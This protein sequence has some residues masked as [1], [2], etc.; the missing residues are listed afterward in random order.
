MSVK[1]LVLIFRIRM[2]NVSRSL[3]LFLFCVFSLTAGSQQKD[4]DRLKKE[5]EE[6][7]KKIGFT[8]KLL[9]STKTNK[10]NLTENI[11]LIE[12]KIEYR[13]EL[14]NNLD[15]QLS[16]L[17]ME[18]ESMKEEIEALRLEIER[19]KAAYKAM[20][21]HAYKM[22]SSSSSLIFI[23]SSESFNQASKRMA[24]LKQLSK[25]R[26]DQIIKI[27]ATKKKL[28]TELADLELKKQE[29]DDLM[30]EQKSEH[31]KYISD[32]ESQKKQIE[33][34]KGKE[35]QLQ[36]ELAAQKKKVK[37]IQNA[38]NAALN[39]EILDKKKKKDEKPLTDKEIKEVELSNKGFEA[40]K[41]KLPWPVSKGEIT[42]GYGKQAHPVHINVYTQNNGVD[43]TTSKG[44]TVRAVYAGEVT[45]VILIPG[46]GKAVIIAHGDYR[47]IY[48]NLQEAYVTKGAKVETKQDIGYLLANESGTSEV[49]FEICKITTE[50]DIIHVN[51]TYW[52]TQ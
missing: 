11:G 12:R 4:S 13:D 21:V 31:T 47:S 45:S 43:I 5:Q 10:Q 27:Q 26:S 15:K 32:R 2:L 29:K 9:E 41:G 46:A 16:Q 36:Q 39:K 7:K 38:L 24:Y 3:L 14:L 52:I 44:A 23:L 17:S 30:V 33:N 35:T 6:L 34:L 49:H 50:G 1:K 20:L 28:D 42:K 48:S 8:E 40:D 37:D 22:R 18:I 19:Q 25:F 51:P